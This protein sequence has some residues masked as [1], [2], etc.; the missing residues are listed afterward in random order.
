MSH[1]TPLPTHD[2]AEPVVP[3]KI[4]ACVHPRKSALDDLELR[5]RV[6]V[7]TLDKLIRSSL[8]KSTFRDK[9]SERLYL[10]ERELLRTYESGIDEW[11]YRTV[12]Y[13][14]SRLIGIGRRLPVR[15]MG[16]HNI[17]RE[18]RHTLAILIYLDFDMVNCH[19]EIMLQITKACA[20]HISHVQLQSYCED[21]DKWVRHITAHTSCTR[22]D[23]KRLILRYMYGGGFRGWVTETHLDEGL[24]ESPAM[25]ALS[26]ELRGITRFIAR[27][28]P[29]I[30]DVVLSTKTEF[31]NIDGSTASHV[32]QEIECRMLEAVYLYCRST[33]IIGDDM[34]AV[35]CADGIMLEKDRC[36]DDLCAQLSRVVYEAT[37]FSMKFS[38]KPMDQ[39]YLDILDDCVDNSV[40]R[41]EFPAAVIDTAAA[42]DGEEDGDEIGD[43]G[44]PPDIQFVS[45]SVRLDKPPAFSEEGMCLMQKKGMDYNS[46]RAADMPPY[47]KLLHLI[48]NS[49]DQCREFCDWVIMAIRSCLGNLDD[50][51]EWRRLHLEAKGM[52][53]SDIRYNLKSDPMSSQF[54]LMRLA[55]RTSPDASFLMKHAKKCH[56]KYFDDSGY[57]I[58]TFLNPQI[59]GRFRIITETSRYMSQEGTEFANDIFS[60]EKILIMDGPP[61]LGKTTAIKRLNKRAKYDRILCLSSRITFALFIAGEFNLH[62][63]KDKIPDKK[64]PTRNLALEQDKLVI[65]LESLHL[66]EGATAFDVIHID[67]CESILSIFTS[68]T[69]GGRHLVAYHV[70]VDFIKRARK[71]IFASAF[72][73]RKTINFVNFLDMPTC[74]IR[75]ITKPPAREAVEVPPDKYDD[76]LLQ[77]I[78]D[79][80]KPFV[81]WSSLTRHKEFNEKLKEQVPEAYNNQ[82]IYTS[83]TDDAV[84]REVVRANE[85]WVNAALVQCTLALNVG[86]SFTK[87]HLDQV[88]VQAH[89]TGTAMDNMQQSM[90]VRNLVQNK[91]VFS[92]PPSQ[93]LSMNRG[94]HHAMF[95]LI[96][97]YDYHQGR[98][99]CVL[100]ELCISMVGKDDF[101]SNSYI[102]RV[103][104]DIFNQYERTPLPLRTIIMDCLY[105]KGLSC[106]YYKELFIAL[107][108][109][110]NYNVTLLEGEIKEGH[111]RACVAADSPYI[112]DGIEPIEDDNALDELKK[113]VSM[114]TATNDEKLRITRHKFDNTVNSQD[115]HVSRTLFDIWV[116]Q[117]K[118]HHIKNAVAESTVHASTE[119]IKAADDIRRLGVDLCTPNIG[120]IKVI[121]DIVAILGISHSLEERTG[122]P[123]DTIETALGDYLYT[124]RSAIH[125]TFDLR[126]QCPNAKRTL[127]TTCYFANKVLGA[128]SGTGIRAEGEKGSRDTFHKWTLTDRHGQ[129]LNL[130]CIINATAAKPPSEE[131]VMK[132]A[133]NA[134]DAATNPVSFDDRMQNYENSRLTAEEIK[135]RKIAY[136]QA[137]AAVTLRK[138]KAARAKA[139]VAR[140]ER[141]RYETLK[142]TSIV[143]PFNGTERVVRQRVL[144]DHTSTSTPA[145]TGNSEA[146]PPADT[147]PADESRQAEI[148]RLG[149]EAA[150]RHWA[151]D[152]GHK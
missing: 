136:E 30:R 120:K 23:A 74:Y 107:L 106:K 96:E 3:P 67:E 13:C 100:R 11:K 70:L 32:M 28:N 113:K 41:H 75:N 78:K 21:R 79:G 15:A 128:W 132:R 14:V 69:M 98:R 122:I 94:R 90:R 139:K 86:N 47:R 151:G 92:M 76:L 145:S 25:I 27:S 111:A 116:D 149:A 65:S 17:R 54:S 152:A 45:M 61:G 135:S 141:C 42:P 8:L 77:N 134:L 118:I 59:P 103:V 140:D 1:P 63:Y 83:E 29:H 50:V 99:L 147:N 57:L 124:N 60:P 126:D 5:E 19:P 87:Q 105:E 108:K 37:G 71:V 38:N 58:D 91:L 48:P 68:K 51:Y 72:I 56:P 16:L 35:L 53:E 133:K 62:C 143:D 66:L 64:D 121:K 43:W 88:W 131:A 22:D 127:K 34:S 109:Q 20:P 110:L 102:A 130:S 49:K 137:M 82:F 148:I 112:Y 24:V 138:R 44:A 9:T 52:D 146:A 89:P 114:M 97:E 81:C 33:G 123:R 84:A 150:A 4:S 144:V 55:P 93:I 73:T 40:Q 115:P 125:V 46:L 36:P 7:D 39:G 2:G 104:H 18:I 10:N 95:N 26:G 31:H 101:T 117:H 142:R 129:P 80:L 119:S 85:L 12:K 6:D